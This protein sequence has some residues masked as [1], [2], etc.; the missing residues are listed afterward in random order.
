MWGSESERY[1]E[2]TYYLR[3]YYEPVTARQKHL[4]TLTQTYIGLT[5]QSLGNINLYHPRES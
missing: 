2:F 5:V 4:E 1:C 3:T